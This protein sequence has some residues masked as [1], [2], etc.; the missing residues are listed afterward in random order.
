MRNLITILAALFALSQPAE[1]TFYKTS[2]TQIF[3]HITEP[4]TFAFG[5]FCTRDRDAA[6]LQLQA[7]LLAN[8]D[9][10]GYGSGSQAG[11]SFPTLRDHGFFVT[12]LSLDDIKEAA[13][14][15]DD[16][17]DLNFDHFESQDFAEAGI[18][19]TFFVSVCK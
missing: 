10:R 13:V 19:R 9:F 1:A 16:E 4:S 14:K 3:E 7:K 11:L 18:G 17:L 6:L 8:L 15:I 12:W 5:Q 2:K